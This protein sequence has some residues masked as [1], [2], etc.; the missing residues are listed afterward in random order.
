MFH[1]EPTAET[2]YWNFTEKKKK[3]R[4]YSKIEWKQSKLHIKWHTNF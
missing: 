4:I 3:T 2:M 1:Q